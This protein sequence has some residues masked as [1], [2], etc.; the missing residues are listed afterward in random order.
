MNRCFLVVK[1]SFRAQYFLTFLI[2]N[3]IT[4]FVKITLYSLLPY[5]PTSYRSSFSILKYLN[6]L[7][8]LQMTHSIRLKWLTR[9]KIVCSTI[10]IPYSHQYKRYGVQSFWGTSS[11]VICYNYEAPLTIIYC[12]WVGAGKGRREYHLISHLITEPVNTRFNHWEW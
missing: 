7:K 5:K 4:K 12:S 1:K 9:F 11:T 8:W 2:K 10:Q 3:F 6:W